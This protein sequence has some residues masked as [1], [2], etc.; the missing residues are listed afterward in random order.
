MSLIGYSRVST[1]DQSLS[2]QNEQLIAAGVER[3]FSE[4]VSAVS[5]KDRHQL[6]ACLDFVRDGDILLVTRLDRLA[7]SVPDLRDIIAKL[8]RKRVGFRCL[9]QPV[10]TTS[11]A[12]R[13]MINMLGAFAEFELDIRRER[14]AEGIA[15]AKAAGKYAK[16]QP[17]PITPEEIVRQK[18]QGKSARQIAR[19]Y[20]IGQA[21]VYRNSPEGLWTPAP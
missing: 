4:Q 19:E 16:K 8:E 21:T 7:R 3:I 10:E 20:R 11:S 6:A 2:V 13:L 1:I 12:G 17:P 18:A 15:K 14:Q 9:L 5:T